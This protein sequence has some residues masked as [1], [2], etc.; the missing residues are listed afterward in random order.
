MLVPTQYDR[1]FS[2][3]RFAS[4]DV[5]SLRMLFSTS[6]PLRAEVKRRVLDE[7]RA[8][9]VEIYGLTEGGPVT[10]LEC[11]QHPDKLGT[12][13][14]PSPG[15]ELRVVDE[16]GNDVPRGAT[17]EI[18]GRSANMM[19]GYLNR[20]E[21]TAALV[22]RDAAEEKVY[23]R[24]GD[25]GRIDEDGF[26]C[27]LDRK[28]DVII[29]GGFNVYATDLETVLARHEAVSEVAVIGVPSERWGETPL[30]LVVRRS[31]ARAT[32]G[33]LLAWL[34]ERVGKAQR[35]FRV[36]FRRELPKSPIGKILKRELREPYWTTSRP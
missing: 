15:T 23:F 18:L 19:S 2:S 13:G 21:E 27:L 12:V 11:R 34:N 3:P 10:V 16:S 30:A 31:G 14:K 24:T 29:S 6:A 32:E 28:K 17:G 25:I 5:S 20:S 4:A 22:F 9:L 36:E 35:A 1:L 8:E 7:T 26:L 33:E